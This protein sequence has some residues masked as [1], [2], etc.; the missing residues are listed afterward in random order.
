MTCRA[1][2]LTFAISTSSLMACG[3][4][5]SKA[6]I[7]PRVGSTPPPAAPAPA[8]DPSAVEE[9]FRAEG[10]EVLLTVD[11]GTRVVGV[12]FQGEGA[13]ATPPREHVRRW[14]D[15]HGDTLGY[16]ALGLME[17]APATRAPPS[18][19][20]IRVFQ[21]P[22]AEACPGLRLQVG[23][24]SVAERHRPY[25]WHLACPASADAESQTQQM[26]AEM[27]RY[28][29][30]LDQRQ[31]RGLDDRLA[32]WAVEE[33]LQ[34]TRVERASEHVHIEFAR[35]TV[36]P[37]PSAPLRLAYVKGLAQRAAAR[38]GLPAL[39][40]SQLTRPDSA[41]TQRP[42]PLALRSH[43]LELR[44]ARPPLDGECI[45]PR[46]AISLD[47]EAGAYVLRAL[48]VTCEREPSA[49]SRAPS[50]DARALPKAASGPP[51]L[52][53]L[54]ES[55][56][57]AAG[58]H[59]Q[60]TVI[61]NRGD[62]FSFSGGPP[63]SATS[64][65]ALLVRVR[66]GRRYVATIP[67]DETDRLVALAPIVAREPFVTERVK[68]FDAP[69]SRCSLLLRGARPGTL[70]PVMLSAS[71]RSAGQRSG[72]ASKAVQAALEKAGL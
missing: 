28:G 7:V 38:E 31:A 2:V 5:P 25:R 48:D 20:S 12:A 71:G 70:V 58:N 72:P 35:T 32:M 19:L 51:R 6:A 56:N 45:D 44:L 26:H 39:D 68:V 54:C 64:E 23:Y 30:S 52:L 41:V 24:V 9:A 29:M 60:G 49:G 62:V 13:L 22:F 67:P 36:P 42:S 59:H 57:F 21:F 10:L 15:A 47:E 40:T 34:P 8:F 4:P 55:V 46:L 66:N 50:D 33:G 63:F 11:G 3:S 61:D 1:Y 65:H 53:A 17:S 37:A 16:G 14:M 27:V 43:R 69:S 18:A